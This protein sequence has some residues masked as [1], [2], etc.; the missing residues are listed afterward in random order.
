MNADFLAESFSYFA[1]CN[2]DSAPELFPEER[3][4]VLLLIFRLVPLTQ[5]PHSCVRTAPA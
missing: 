4:N 1:C 3:Q 2:T 5:S